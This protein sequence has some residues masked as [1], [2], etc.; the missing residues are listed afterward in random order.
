M[1]KKNIYKD[2]ILNEPLPMKSFG[3]IMGDKDEINKA[4][5]FKTE[6]LVALVEHYKFPL[7]NIT[8]IALPL[9]SLL[10]DCHPAFQIQEKKKV[11]RRKKFG[12]F[13]KYQLYADVM[14]KALKDK[15]IIKACE[16]LCS[17]T[18][19]YR[20]QYPPTLQARFNEVKKEIDKL[21]IEPKTLV[22]RIRNWE[23]RIAIFDKISSGIDELDACRTLCS[24]QGRY[25]GEK[26]EELLAHYKKEQKRINEI[27]EGVKRELSK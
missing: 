8:S 16:E 18:N 7:E 13:I 4:I 14:E 5:K 11:G 9:L 22:E 10:E 23:L 12:G 19:L 20:K 2:P 17:T 25:H 27:T 1:K 15:S 24:D 6:K 3:E 21:N 26:P